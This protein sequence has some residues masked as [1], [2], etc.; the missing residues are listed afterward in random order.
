MLGAAQWAWLEA[1][2]VGSTAAVHVI[3]SS[4]QVIADEH[5]K[6]TWGRFPASRAKLI[7]LLDVANPRNVVF[8]SG[9]RHLAEL[10]MMP[11]T[12][13]PDVVDLT[14]SGMSRH[15]QERVEPN[16]HRV[17]PMINDVNFGLVRVD[18]QA[19]SIRLQI[20]DAAGADRIDHTLRLQ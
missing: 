1:Q 18:W 10:S 3:G 17:G 20:K 16:R 13:G 7:A 9:D 4:I 2:L 15:S 12:L 8:I 14:S 11:R 6:E 5:G 19:R